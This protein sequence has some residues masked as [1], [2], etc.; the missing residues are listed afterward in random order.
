MPGALAAGALLTFSLAAAEAGWWSLAAVV[1]A[2]LVALLTACS[3]AD[4]AAQSGP[5][6]GYPHVRNRLGA[7]PGRL[8]GV[9][10]LG[11]RLVAGTA[12]AGAAGA[13]LLPGQPIVAAVGLVVVARAVAVGGFRPSR[14]VARVTAAVVIVTLGV[15][16]AV[17]F[18]IE[19]AGQVAAVEPGAPGSD[20]PTGLLAAAG[21][22]FFGFLGFERVAASGARLRTG[23]VTVVAVAAGALLVGFAA[24]R[25][26]GGPRLAYS[27]TPLRDALAA[28]DG[29]ALD[30]LLTAGLVVGA[31]VALHSLLDG[32]DDLVRDMAATGDLPARFADHRTLLT[33]ALSAGAAV[34]LSPAFATALAAA[35]MLGAFAFV[36]SAAR[37]LCRAE[38]S[39]WV[40]T[41]CCGLAL[42]VLVGVNISIPALIGTAAVLAVGAGLCTVSARARAATV[43]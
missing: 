21:L 32:A 31:L 39:T 16:V 4:L 23:L 1:L 19:P 2:G 6:G 10:E 14:A 17:A 36:N 34:L 40:R 30:P 41:G 20:D 29:A 7:V 35:L 37:T 26:L 8:A 43:G 28:A 15:F 18:A 33:G 12:V 42:C 27:P 24:L 38:R 22:L 13:Y 25:Q 3:L 11:G 9:L 5:G